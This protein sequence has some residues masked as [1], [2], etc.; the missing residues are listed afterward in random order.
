MLEKTIAP[1]KHS[2]IEPAREYVWPH[3]FETQQRGIG[4][5]QPQRGQQQKSS[6][7]SC[8]LTFG[9]Y[10]VNRIRGDS[11]ARTPWGGTDN[12]NIPTDTS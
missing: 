1:E 3:H 8:E 9:P 7:F 5:Q 4:I 2:N 12:L 11:R 10:G 6:F